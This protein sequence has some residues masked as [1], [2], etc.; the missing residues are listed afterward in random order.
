[1]LVVISASSI[2]S[3]M[4][5]NCHNLYHFWEDSDVLRAFNLGSNESLVVSKYTNGPLE[6]RLFA[7]N[8]GRAQVLSGPHHKMLRHP[9]F[10]AAN[11]L[12]MFLE[13]QKTLTDISEPSI[14]ASERWLPIKNRRRHLRQSYLKKDK[15]FS[16]KTIFSTW[17]HKEIS[18]AHTAKGSSR[19]GI[20]NSEEKNA[21]FFSYPRRK[22]KKCSLPSIFAPNP[23]QTTTM[24]SF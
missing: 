13:L 5:S 14:N 15:I 10:C 22:C 16:K 20:C 3:L 17:K 8:G 21:F 12:F 23:Q 18:D 11:E 1:M 4:N 2:T 6:K 9:L 24:S 19:H 7:R